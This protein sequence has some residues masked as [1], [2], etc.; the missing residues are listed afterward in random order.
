MNKIITTWL[1]FLI[2]FATTLPARSITTDNES[3][4]P[5]T[6]RRHR[7]PFSPEEYLKAKNEHIIKRVPLSPQEAS[8][9][10]PLLQK[11]KELQRKNDKK[12]KFLKRKIAETNNQQEC[13]KLLENI[14][15]LKAANLQI[16]KKYTQ[17][18]MEKISPKKCMRVINEEE[19]FNFDMLRKMVNTPPNGKPAEQN[20]N[21]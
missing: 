20:K 4:T 12:I 5:A 3:R 13:M 9:I 10:L 16:E 19:R 15:K 21:N 6:E 17:K 18:M 1:L 11:Q 7:P 8:F 2:A 14:F